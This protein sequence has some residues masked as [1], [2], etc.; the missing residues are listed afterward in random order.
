VSLFGGVIGILYAKRWGG[1]KSYFGRSILFFS[2]GLLAQFIGQA[3]YAWFI[4]VKGVAVPY[5]SIGDVGYYGSVWLYILGVFELSK[6]LV[7]KHYKFKPLYIVLSYGAPTLMV[8]FAYVVFLRG[9]DLTSV[10]SLTAFLDFAY[11][12][13]QAVYVAMAM[14][15]YFGSRNI[16]GGH[17][18]GPAVLLLFSLII[19]YVA[20]FMFLFE[21]RAGTWYVG[22]L[23]DYL[24]LLSYCAM[25]FALIKVNEVYKLVSH[26]AS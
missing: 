15:T 21:S 6:V 11:P 8:V 1:I 22:G 19:Q 13:T 4:Y 23:N 9:Y 5:P 24:Y 12:L 10:P 3:V 20:D 16:L 14:V 7:A 26:N 18:R 25:A 2:L 17:M